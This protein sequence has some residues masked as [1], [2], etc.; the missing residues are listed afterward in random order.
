MRRSLSASTAS[1]SA[2][3]IL[4]KASLVGAKIVKGP[5]PFRVSTRSASPTAVTRVDSSGLLEAAVAAGSWAMPAKLPA[6]SFGTE[7]Q[8]GP[9]GDIASS[10]D[11]AAV[12]EPP[13][14]VGDEVSPSESLPQAAT[15]MV[16]ARAMPMAPTRFREMCMVELAFGFLGGLVWLGEIRRSGGSVTAR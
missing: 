11:A 4:A 7:A 5:G 13:D 14:V 9:V 12:V 6:P 16:R 15:L 2:A 1:R 8:P 3:G 10:V